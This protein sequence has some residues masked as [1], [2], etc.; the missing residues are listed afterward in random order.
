LE[1]TLNTISDVEPESFKE[2]ME[3]FP[4]LVGSDEKSFRSTR[5]LKNGAFIETNLSAKYIYSL[6]LRSI[7]IA[8]FSIQDW[9]VDTVRS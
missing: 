9:Y 7:G 6:C 4:R 5:K 1:I 2:I 8:E 3:Q